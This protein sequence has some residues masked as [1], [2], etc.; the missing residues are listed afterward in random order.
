MQTG[1]FRGCKFIPS[2]RTIPSIFNF[3][4]SKDGV[5]K[6]V[7]AVH[8]TICL[9]NTGGPLIERRGAKRFQVDWQIR[10]EGAAASESSFVETGVLR[11]I[12]SSGALLSLR[13]SLSTGT[14]LDVYI[15]L[16]LTGKKWMRYPACVV[17]SEMGWAAVTFES[18][19]PDFG[20]QGTPN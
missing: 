11:N 7:K 14:Q 2:S 3:N 17:R 13:Y 18:A 10:V 5:K 4:F 6:A 9:N 20:L 1:S 8:T 15:E 16:P 12:S 19:R